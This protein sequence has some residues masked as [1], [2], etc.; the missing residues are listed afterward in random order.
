MLSS[1]NG[2]AIRFSE[3]DARPMGRN[4]K[5]VRGIKLVGEDEVVGMVVADPEG[6][7]LT[8]SEN[9]YGKRTPFG[10]NTADIGDDGEGDADAEDKADA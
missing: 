10:P 4:T 8:V 7:L 6:Q 9:G 5:G 3:A 2:M 1:R